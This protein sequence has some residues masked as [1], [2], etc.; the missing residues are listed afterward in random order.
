MRPLWASRQC[1]IREDTAD[2]LTNVESM[3]T[4]AQ[5]LRLSFFFP[6]FFFGV[7]LEAGVIEEMD[8][9]LMVISCSIDKFIVIESSWYCTPLGCYVFNTVV[10]I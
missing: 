1:F 3:P 9:V 4:L 5:R 7:V 8:G 10:F 6:F 2:P